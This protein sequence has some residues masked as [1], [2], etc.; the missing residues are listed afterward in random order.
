MPPVFAA[1]LNIREPHE[2]VLGFLTDVLEAEDGTEQRTQLRTIETRTESYLVSA[3]DRAS[4]A[5][6][7]AELYRMQGERMVVPAWLD[8]T[9]LTAAASEGATTLACVTTDRGFVVGEYAVLWS[10]PLV[11]EAVEITAVNA[12]DLEVVPTDL[13]WS[14]HALVMPGR[15]GK[16][17]GDQAH[18]RINPIATDLVVAF[19]LETVETFGVADESGEEVVSFVQYG[20]DYVVYGGEP[21]VYTAEE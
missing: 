19:G 3:Y 8:F 6:L 2:T 9:R 21:V 5:R 10:S 16:L 11:C 18:T 4:V 14:E 15:V 13:A 20:G 17:I 12:N 7:A 1:K